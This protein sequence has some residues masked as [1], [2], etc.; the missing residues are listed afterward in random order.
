MDSVA[1]ALNH[2][3]LSVDFMGKS[4]AMVHGACCYLQNRDAHKMLSGH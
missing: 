2:P 1:V 3:L 4:S